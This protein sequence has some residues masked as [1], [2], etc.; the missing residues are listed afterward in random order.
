MERNSPDAPTQS[1]QLANTCKVVQGHK[2]GHVGCGMVWQDCDALLSVLA[3]GLLMLSR[4]S[5]G[6]L[7]DLEAMLIEHPPSKRHSQGSNWL[8]SGIPKPM[9]SGSLWM[10]HYV[11]CLWSTALDMI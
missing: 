6:A 5:N 4:L 11:K 3:D 10:A 9:K 7:E 1:G 2:A 8:V